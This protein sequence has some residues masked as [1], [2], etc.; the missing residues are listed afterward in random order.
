[1]ITDAAPLN[2]STADLITL[3]GTNLGPIMSGIS[4]RIGSQN[5]YP[6]SLTQA[7]SNGTQ[8]LTCQLS[9]LNLGDQYIQLNVQGRK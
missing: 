1:M 7:D 5:C 6:V 9:G 2:V 3:R 8:E 4:T